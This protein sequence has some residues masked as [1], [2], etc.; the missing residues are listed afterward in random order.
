M[1]KKSQFTISTFLSL[2][3]NYLNFV[4][5]FK[6]NIPAKII[7]KLNVYTNEYF[8]VIF[9]RHF[10]FLETLFCLD[11]LNIILSNFSEHS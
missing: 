7:T 1:K 11:F 4:S 2:F 10:L 5:T 3:L 8:S 9:I 6:N